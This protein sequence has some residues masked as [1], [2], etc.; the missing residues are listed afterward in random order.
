M[1]CESALLVNILTKF[2]CMYL[3]LGK[4]LLCSETLGSILFF[5]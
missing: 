4:V 5:I 1:S 3:D 2:T